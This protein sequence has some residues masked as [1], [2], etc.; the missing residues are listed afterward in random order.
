MLSFSFLFLR[1]DAALQGALRVA[2]AAR[3]PF[4]LRTLLISRGPRAFARA[5]SDLSGHAIVDALSLLG[6]AD[7]AAVSSRLPQ[8]ARQRLLDA[9]PDREWRSTPVPTPPWSLL[10]MR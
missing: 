2:V 8:A 5:L 3:R 10:V 6:A 1:S 9:A 7:R 4:V